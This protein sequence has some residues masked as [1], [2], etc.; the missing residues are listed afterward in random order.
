[1][2][3]TVKPISARERKAWEKHNIETLREWRAISFTD[4][5]RILEE[6]E[7]LARSTH[8]GQES[9]KLRG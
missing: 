8:G 1:M 9:E 7:D 2:D 6:M 5:I 4:K 3:L